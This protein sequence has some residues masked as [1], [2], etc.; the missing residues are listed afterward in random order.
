MRI[1]HFVLACALTCSAVPAIA[2]APY[3]RFG[4]AAAEPDVDAAQVA[5]RSW[6]ERSAAALAATGQARDL[7]LAATLRD[8]ATRAPDD[9][10]TEAPSVAAAPDPRA[11]AWRREAATRA[12]DDMLANRL[13]AHGGDAATRL[14]M[15][16]RWLG[17]EPQNFAPLLMRGGDMDV[18]LA[19]ARSATRFDLHMLD[20][21]RWMQA[22]LLR[23]P[24]TAAE[25]AALLGG[26]AFVPEESAAIHAMTLWSAFAMPAINPL[27]RACDAQAMRDDA[28]RR[29]D[30]R[31]VASLMADHSDTQLG[32][33]IGLLLLDRL[34]GSATE[35]AGI[36]ARR[37]ALD[38]RN[39]EWGRASMTL[40]RDG[41]GQLVR[42][43]ADPTIRT[44]QDLVERALQEA[45]ISPDPSPG[46]QPPSGLAPQG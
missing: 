5:W 27:V 43:L 42:F 35:R 34:A 3:A 14:R 24:P 37:R 33:M 30:C 31:H 45:G 18:M 38:W 12:G 6:S 11:D 10:D 28:P 40:P 23:T 7:A 13:L 44:E 46:W 1:R 15:A 16:Q 19:D 21:V 41:A 22:A 8:V 17:T 25:R 29:Q 39:L 36:A 32:T 20:D 26:E 9:P 4:E 2:Q